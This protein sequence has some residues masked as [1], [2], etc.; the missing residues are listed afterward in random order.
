[1]IWFN[2]FVSYF[3]LIAL[4]GVGYTAYCW[5][6]GGNWDVLLYP[7]LTEFLDL[8]EAS[9]WVRTLVYT[10]FTV[11]FLPYLVVY[12]VF[13]FAYVITIACVVNRKWKKSGKK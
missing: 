1:M 11:M 2:F 6:S 4:A 10:V 13:L 12:Y 7:T 9:S 3:I 5:N 8:R